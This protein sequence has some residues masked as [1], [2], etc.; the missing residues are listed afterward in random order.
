VAGTAP[1][2]G[3][4]VPALA[5]GAMAAIPI[6]PAAALLVGTKSTP[7]AASGDVWDTRLGFTSPLPVVPVGRYAATV[8]FTAIGR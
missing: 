3:Q 5:G 1:T 6:A 7:S 2:G 8:T 4:V